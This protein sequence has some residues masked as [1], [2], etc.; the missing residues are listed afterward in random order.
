MATSAS[1]STSKPKVQKVQDEYGGIYELRGKLAEGGQGIVVRTNVD[2]LLVKVCRWPDSDP[3]SEVWRKQVQSV[4][5]LPAFD[6]G[7]PVVMPKARIVKPR[8]GYVM[9]LI[10]GLIPLEQL[11][12]EAA[13]ATADGA[14]LKGFVNSGG[15]AR[16]LRLLSRLARVLARLHGLAIAH[17]DISPKNVFVSSSNDQGEVWLIDCDNLTYAVRDSSLQLY[18]PDYGAPEVLR[19]DAGIST[20]TDIWSFAVIAFQ[21]LTLLHPFKSGVLVDGN[22]DLES[23]ALRGE[24]PWI[25]HRDDDRNRSEGWGIPRAYALT[26]ALESLFDRCFRMGVMD[27]EQRPVMAEWAEALEAA[28]AQQVLCREPDGCGSTFLWNA[29]LHCPFCDTRH[30]AAIALRLLHSI[31]AP[32]GELGEDATPA[33]SWI[34]TGYQ[35]AVGPSK[36]ELRSAPP[37]SS[38][39][40][41]SAVVATIHLDGDHLVISPVR[42]TPL[43]LQERG[44]SRVARLPTGHRIAREKRVRAIH[45]GELEACHDA[46]RFKW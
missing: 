46:W 19:G 37:G 41:E 3:R 12:K 5:R 11:L 27:I 39:Y 33:D 38:A 44:T 26:P 15:L 13:E 25:D 29:E 17:G 23:S 35:L 16:R 22:A 4:Q 45:I 32:R 14:G 9:Q 8:A 43:Y 42:D 34:A 30:D 36:V 21:L 7:L 24:L 28:A 18:T 6:Q 20:F 10:D 40:L 31:H 1:T 2:N